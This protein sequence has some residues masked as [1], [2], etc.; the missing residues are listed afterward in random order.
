MNTTRVGV[1]V[2]IFRHFHEERST[3]ILLGKRKG[4]HGEGEWAFPGGS[5]EYGESFKETALRELAEEVGPQFKIDENDLRVCA[6]TNLTAYSGK[7][8]V[9]IGI[10]TW[11][12]EGDPI[13]MEPDKVEGWEWVGV[14]KELPAPLFATVQNTLN[15]YLSGTCLVY[16]CE[17]KVAV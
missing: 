10:S 4:S 17:S 3:K 1:G 15:G 11:W 13:T 6:V 12:L 14:E 8:Y 7:H 9:D 2:I 5:M 16:D